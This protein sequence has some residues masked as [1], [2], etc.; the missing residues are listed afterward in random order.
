MHLTATLADS[1]MESEQVQAGI[2]YWTKVENYVTD[3]EL[4][5]SI[6]TVV[7]KII[8]IWVVGRLVIKLSNK[9]IDHMSR[10]RERNLLKIDQRRSKT[11]SRLVGNVVSWTVNF[12]TL[13]LVLS[14]MGFNLGPLLAGAG[15][16]GLAIGFGAQSLVKDV[17]TG[18]FIIFED[19]FAVGD[20]IQIGAQKGTVEQIGLRVTRIRSALGE[21]Y[22]IP[23][24]SIGQVTNFSVHNATALIDI[25][26][27]Y[28][29]DA[30]RV[31]GII[32]ETL[33]GSDTRIPHLVA[34]PKVLGVQ[35]MAA[36]DISIRVEAECEPNTD[37]MVARMLNAEIK[38]A[39]DAHGIRKAPA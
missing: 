37:A 35:T 34:E 16:L 2:G 28:K 39:L 12:I 3:P 38:Q 6:I 27:P 11:I 9:A 23:N 18:F 25:L 24:G 31:V 33:K 13:L 22:I 7:I 32:N 20:V 29:E 26:V 30:E 15:V 1:L 5:S 21:E 10:E 4:W 14:Q 17:I 19:Q 8:V 36:A